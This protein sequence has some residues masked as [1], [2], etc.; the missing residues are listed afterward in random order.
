MG[1][2]SPG[3]EAWRERIRRRVADAENPGADPVVSDRA[4]EAGIADP[5][6]PK[7]TLSGLEGLLRLV[8]FADARL[9]KLE[10]AA[11]CRLIRLHRVLS[12]RQAGTQSPTFG[13]RP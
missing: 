3:F 2:D 8:E 13:L 4:D 5:I 6:F 12:A 10:N 7:L 1:A 11:G 9:E